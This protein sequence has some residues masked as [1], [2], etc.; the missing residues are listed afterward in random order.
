[1]L[2]PIFL[3]FDLASPIASMSIVTR[4]DGNLWLGLWRSDVRITSLLRVTLDGDATELP[5][6][7]G[8][9]G[10]LVGLTVGPDANLWFTPSDNRV[11]RL[12]S[13]G[14][15]DQVLADPEILRFH[16]DVVRLHQDDAPG[17]EKRRRVVRTCAAGR[18]QGQ[19]HGSDLEAAGQG[20]SF[21]PSVPLTHRWLLLW[22]HGRFL[23]PRARHATCAKT[24][25]NPTTSSRRPGRP[26]G[27]VA[28][29]DNYGWK[30]AIS[31]QLA[32]FESSKPQTRLKEQPS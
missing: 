1:M 3:P 4:A 23:A 14:D 26:R 22:G 9:N 16:H 27:N 28:S 17:F 10:G 24:K 5:L 29:R 21:D 6:P 11:G 15:P 31:W 8:D 13:Q 18:R 19:E 32:N 7:G 20:Q 25:A 2:T 30:G 12:T